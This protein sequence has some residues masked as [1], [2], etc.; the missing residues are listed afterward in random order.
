[1]YPCLFN[2]LHDGADHDLLP[3]AYRIDVD[4]YRRTE[5]TI[6][7]DGRVVRDAHRI[8]HV[9]QQIIQRGVLERAASC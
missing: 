6:Q 2:V 8:A 3:I 9:A 4:L 7:Q 1:M 5:K